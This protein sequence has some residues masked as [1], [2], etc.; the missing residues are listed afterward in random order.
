MYRPKPLPYVPPITEHEF[1]KRFYS[2]NASLFCRHHILRHPKLCSCKK[3]ACKTHSSELMDLL[4]KKLTLLDEQSNQREEFWGLYARQVVTFRW[5]LAYNFLCF[6][7]M[8]WF[9]FIWLFALGQKRDL[10]DAFVPTSVMISML[11]VFWSTFL[12]SLHF[13]RDK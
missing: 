6:L 13:G 12:S 2:F 7:P 9:V 5:I 11:S 4:P 3:R 10:Q 1:R 8:L